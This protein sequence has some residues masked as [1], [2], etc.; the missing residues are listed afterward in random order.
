MRALF[1]ILI[2]IAQLLAHEP[3][4]S[5][6]LVE[7]KID[8]NIINNVVSTTR[9]G[10]AYR[11]HIKH[12]ILSEGDN[13]NFDYYLLVDPYPSYGTEL[14]VQFHKNDIVFIDQ[15]DVK[16]TLDELMGMELYLQHGPL[17]DIDSLKVETTTP[18]KT[19]ITFKLNKEAM[20]R[21]LKHFRD[22]NGYIYIIDGKLEKIILK[23]NK[24][25]ELRN[26]EV[27][28]YEKSTYFK[29]VS[30]GGYLMSSERLKIQGLYAGLPY[31]ETL[32]GTV[33]E[34]WNAKREEITFSVGTQKN[35]I[36]IDDAQYETVS[37]D[38]DRLFPL[39]GQE[40]RKAGYDLPKPFG[41]TFINMFQDTLMHMT[42]FKID[43]VPIDFNKILDGDS[44]Y[45][46]ITYAPLVRA[47]IW[48]LPFVSFSLILGG[49]D[50]NTDVSLVS[51]SGLENP[52]Y[53]IT[54]DEYIIAPGSTLNLDAFTTNAIL[55]G[56]GAT[57]AGGFNNYFTTIDFQY[58]VAYTPSAEV[59][60]DMMIITPLIGYSFNE[61]NT[62]L[63]IG[64]QYQRL[65]QQLTFN[66][67]IPNS[68]EKLSG[69]IGL[70]S[71]EWA[72]VIGTDYTFTRNWSANL[73]YSEGVD[74]RNMILGIAYRF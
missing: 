4:N 19:I 5:N 31:S 28:S 61:Y 72:G 49:T 65:A 15:S 33:T 14:K 41:I 27:N 74:R 68:D 56:V 73:L 48:V 71:D 8:P 34:Y 64:A 24:R 3:F 39:L 42:S 62:R 18:T 21:E 32:D 67:D 53:P 44:T 70:R 25:F 50:T 38:L 47:D 43:G 37:V 59:S 52:L 23:N 35:I 36:N 16:K 57:V 54:G 1:L 26:I 51:E 12:H 55:Y 7:Y 30:T 22:I 58:I 9:Q 10:V 17:Y 13:E 11:M 66:V 2:S 60:V 6:I 45:R 69:E 40:A 63:F 20:P 46:S 29:P